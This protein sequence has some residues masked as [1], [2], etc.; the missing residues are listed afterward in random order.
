MVE[1][2]GAERILV[3]SACDWGPSVPWAVAQFIREMRRRSHSED[4][5]RRIVWDNPCEFLGQSLKFAAPGRARAPAV[6]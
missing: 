6:V 5:I 2:F 1:V 3:A 4:L